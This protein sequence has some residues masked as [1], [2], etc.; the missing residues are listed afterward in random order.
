MSLLDE[1]K[2]RN[3]I[4]MAGLYL[5]GAWLATQVAGTVLPIFGAPD[6]MARAVV[7]LLAIGL[8][9]TGMLG[10]FLLCCT[11]R[12]NFRR[13]FILYLAIAVVPLLLT[14]MALLT[15]DPGLEHLAEGNIPLFLVLLGIVGY[16]VWAYR[17]RGREVP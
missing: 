15:C 2:R 3:V 13:H 17:E 5:V 10:A 4:R 12:D 6:W 8:L 9:S 1:L 16:A 11:C 14:G 7:I